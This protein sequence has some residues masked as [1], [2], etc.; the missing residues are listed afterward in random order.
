MPDRHSNAVAQPE[1]DVRCRTRRLTLRNRVML[2]AVTSLAGL[3]TVVY[4]LSSSMILTSFTRLEKQLALRESARALRAIEQRIDEVDAKTVDL[5]QSY[6]TSDFTDSPSANYLRSTVDVDALVALRIN[7]I[8]IMDPR[9]RMLY[10]LATELD[11]AEPAPLPPDLEEQLGPAN[12]FKS[13]RFSVGGIKGLLNLRQGVLFVAARP[14]VRADGG[15]PPRGCVVLGRFLDD[16]ER[17]YVTSMIN[18]TLDFW[19][20][21]S[22]RLSSDMRQAVERFRGDERPYIRVPDPQSICGYF[23]MFDLNDRPALVCRLTNPRDVFARGRTSLNYFLVMLV[24]VGLTFGLLLR[25]LL[26]QFVLDRVSRLRNAVMQISASRDLNQR[27]ELD[28]NDELTD[29]ARVTDRMVRD[30]ADAQRELKEARL[31]AETAAEAKSRFL[32]NMSHEIRTPINGILGFARLLDSDADQGQAGERRDWVRTIHSCSQHLLE[33]IN[34]ILDFSKIEAGRLQV[35]RVGCQPRELIAEVVG[36]MRVR[37][38]EK[39][40]KL[41]ALHDPSTPDAILAD[42]TRLRQVLTNLLANAIKF[43]ESGE[44]VIATKLDRV[45]ARP[46]MAIEVTDTGCGIPREKLNAIFD[47]FVQ[48]DTSVTRRY[49]GTGLGL[50]ISRHIAEAMNGRLLVTSQIGRGST[51]RLEIDPG[52]IEEARKAVQRKQA[53]VRTTSASH[54]AAEGS[55]LSGRILL[56]EDGETNRKLVSLVLTRAGA[57]VVSAENGRRG[58]EL[59]THEPFDLILMDMQMPVMDGYAATHALRRDG[60]QTPIIAL[61]AHAQQSDQDRCFASGCTGYLAKPVDPELL[62]RTAARFLNPS[63]PP[64]LAE[65][66]MDSPRA[67]LDAAPG[68]AASPQSAPEAEESVPCSLPL[69]DPDFRE[70][71]DEFVERLRCRVEEMAVAYAQN[72]LQA[73]ASL[74]HWLKGAGGTAGFGAFTAPAA[75]LERCARAEERTEL[76]RCLQQIRS[77]SQRVSLSSGATKPKFEVRTP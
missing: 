15:G 26:G 60:L 8:L 74:A 48:A 41:E 2:V 58:V 4:S 10:S 36:L 77:L 20:V 45:G 76:E 59:A 50:A 46:R 54:P 7:I 28:G 38:Q 16:R 73:L 56:V 11:S 14:I 22:N 35:E 37:A 47:P 13:E 17:Q 70:I 53:A 65:P 40:L 43:T 32:A 6:D 21:G 51:F 57:Q 33:L 52:S 39:G 69:D 1:P 72:D 3:I 12:R 5:A 66:A 42:P 29:L 49:G 30:L 19:P 18:G 64:L 34:D 27:I 61:T 75:E 9:G 55:R 23:Q 62:V 44:V 31:R 24:V 67:E 71:A 25:G 63:G 68:I